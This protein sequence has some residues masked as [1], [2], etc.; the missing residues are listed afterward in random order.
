MTSCSSKCFASLL[1]GS[2]LMVFA[3]EARTS[4]QRG[5][6]LDLTSSSR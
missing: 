3:G 1:V 5:A 2:A 6:L 4:G